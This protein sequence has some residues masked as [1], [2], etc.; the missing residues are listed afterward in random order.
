MSMASMLGQHLPALTVLLPALTAVLLLLVGDHGG[1]AHASETG[2]Q[3][4]GGTDKEPDAC[5][6]IFKVAD[7]DEEK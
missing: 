5:G 4:T 2:D 6:K 3:T 7:R 1:D